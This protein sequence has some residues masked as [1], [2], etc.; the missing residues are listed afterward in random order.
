MN[1][2]EDIDSFIL[3]LLHRINGYERF[4]KKDKH[5]LQCFKDPLKTLKQTGSE[6][7]IK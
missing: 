1:K 6:G 4:S 7:L 2:N 5:I 3:A